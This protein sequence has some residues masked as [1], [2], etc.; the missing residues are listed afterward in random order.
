MTDTIDRVLDGLDSA[1]RA[2]WAKYYDTQRKADRL[3]TDLAD[4]RAELDDLYDAY[5]SWW[6]YA[7]QLED[8][9]LH[10]AG[11]ERRPWHYPTTDEDS[12]AS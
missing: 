4:T 7:E 9:I 5:Y 2:G 8:Q 1:R 11:H 3:E 12:S 10:N 6:R